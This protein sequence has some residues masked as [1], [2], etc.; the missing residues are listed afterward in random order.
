MRVSVA[1][2]SV[3]TGLAIIGTG[4][5]VIWQDQRWIG[6]LIVLVGVLALVFDIKIERGHVEVGTPKTLKERIRGMATR[7]MVVVVILLIGISVGLWRFW[8]SAKQPLTLEDLYKKD[9]TDTLMSTNTD[10]EVMLKNPDGG[11][12]IKITIHFKLYMDFRSNTY[13]VSFYVP[14]SPLNFYSTVVSLRDEVKPLSDKTRHDLKVGTGAPGVSYRTA[15]DL[16]FSGAVYIYSPN[17][18]G[19][20]QIGEAAKFYK[21]AGMSLDLRGPDYLVANQ[22]R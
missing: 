15:D 19:P 22:K 1:S 17:V 7:L 11:P 4:A 12:D 10:H 2:G 8:P 5:A 6:V 21:Q 16:N 13:F 14:F 18:L 3:F 9:F 20:I